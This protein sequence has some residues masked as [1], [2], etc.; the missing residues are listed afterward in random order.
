MNRAQLASLER[1]LQT[2][3]ATL[4]GQI[5]L[6]HTKSALDSLTPE[7]K[8]WQADKEF[9][10]RER[11]KLDRADAVL[12]KMRHGADATNS[13]DRWRP[14]SPLGVTA[15]AYKGLFM[16]A[17]NRL[18]SFQVEIGG[19]DFGS[20]VEFKSP[21]AGASLFP[22]VLQPQLTQ[23]LPYEPNRLFAEFLGATMDGPAIE[24]IVHSGNT[25]PAAPVAE[26]GTK[27]DLG[28]ILTTKTVAPIKIAAL[29]S[30]SM[31]ALQDFDTFL[32][33]V[34][35]ELQR[36]IIDAET[37]QIINGSGTAP[38]MTGILHTSGTLSRAVD[39]DQTPLDA[40]QL[41]F[42][43]LRIGSSFATANLV[44]LHPTTWTY[45]R[46]QKD[47]QGRYLLAPDPASGQVETIWGARVVTN[48]KIATGTAIVFDTTKAV[49]AWTRMGLTIEINQYGDT[50]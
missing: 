26:L 8:D 32:S 41:A 50:E 48:T 16:A 39:V 10:D 22:A 25:N 17:K 1:D 5:K 34:P 47:S 30:V 13:A 49:L 2:R 31:E 15:D 36:A 20:E 40:V 27:P 44:A 6:A 12:A 43:D 46:S 38:N 11:D 18:P 3:A 24:F 21:I 33:F 19:K 42:N 29:A 28:M 9:F 4:Q 45:L 7:F 14:V 23:Q 37:N 35:A